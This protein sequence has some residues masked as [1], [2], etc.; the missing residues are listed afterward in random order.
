MTVATIGGFNMITHTMTYS[1]NAKNFYTHRIATLRPQFKMQVECMKDSDTYKA[2][3]EL[4]DGGLISIE[5]GQV[6][7]N[8][9][10]KLADLVIVTNLCKNFDN[11]GNNVVDLFGINNL[12]K[13]EC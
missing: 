7:D 3:E 5:G 9:G 6:V 11:N 2:I 8:D 1:E 13:G 10:N 12:C 4:C